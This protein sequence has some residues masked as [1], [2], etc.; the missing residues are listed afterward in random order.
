MAIEGGVRRLLSAGQK[1]DRR[2]L[3]E[4]LLVNLLLA[5]VVA[6]LFDW[7]VLAPER[8]R[9]AQIESD[10]AARESQLEELRTAREDLAERVA[11]DPV[12]DLQ[13]SRERLQARTEALDHEL[14]S[15][16]KGFVSAGSMADALRDL[17]ADT[18]LRLVSLETRPAERLRQVPEGD[19]SGEGNGTPDGPVAMPVLY[20]HPLEITFEGTFTDALAYLQRAQGLDWDFQW[21]GIEVETADYPRATVTW[22]LHSISLEEA[23]I[24][25]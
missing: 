18:P 22:R 15:A 20:R 9:V 4:R 13:R 3:R 2:P 11:N 19:A 16:A 24:G 5:V 23:V 7:F 12:V 21:D 10:L 6:V 17:L 8:D 14:E 1:L 25:G